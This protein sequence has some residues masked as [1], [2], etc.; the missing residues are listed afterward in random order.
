MFTF[1]E[2]SWFSMYF[3]QFPD[4][5]R[6]LNIIIKFLG[7]F[8]FPGSVGTLRRSFVPKPSGKHRGGSMDFLKI[9]VDMSG[10][11][12]ILIRQY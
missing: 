11:R 7:I 5:S 8:Q 12:A 1:K 9:R 3:L 2:F 10:G 4:I 6:S